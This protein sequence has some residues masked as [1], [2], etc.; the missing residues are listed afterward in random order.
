MI[1]NTTTIIK[2]LLCVGVILSGVTSGARSAPWSD[3][4]IQATSPAKA[5][6]QAQEIMGNYIIFP[7]AMTE[8]EMRN[9]EKKHDATMLITTVSMLVEKVGLDKSSFLLKLSDEKSRCCEIM[10]D[11]IVEPCDPQ[12]MMGHFDEVLEWM[13]KSFRMFE[14]SKE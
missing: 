13:D 7:L 3:A 8:S 12:K 9:C 14:R 1:S 5:A 10:G 2:V 4:T 6:E 11:R